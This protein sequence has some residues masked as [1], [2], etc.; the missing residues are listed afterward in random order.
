MKIAI[1]QFPGSNCERESVLAVKRAGMGSFEFLWNMPSENLINCDGYFIVG[2]F[3]YEDRSRAGIIA[4][5]DPVIKVLRQ[6]SEKGKPV[7][8]I[9]NGAQILIETGLVPGFKN[10]N[11][12]MA[13]AANEKKKKGALIGTGFYN[14]WVNIIPSTES[15]KSA[16]TSQLKQNEIM[17]IPVAH[18]EGRFVTSPSIM[19]I[20]KDNHLDTFRYCTT[21]GE[22]NLDFPV[23]PN[24]SI[25]NLAAVSN[26]GGNVMAMMPHPER[27]TSGDPVFS[28][29]REYISKLKK[30]SIPKLDYQDTV[31]IEK[32]NSDENSNELLIELIITDNE[33]VSVE[34]ALRQMDLSVRVKRYTHWEIISNSSYSNSSL[35]KIERSGELFN[36]NKEMV[37]NYKHNSNTLAFLVRD[38]DNASGKRKKDIL[39]HW[40]HAKNI[41]SIESG[42]LWDITVEKGDV[43]SVI[44][45]VLNTHILYNPYS[46]DCLHYEK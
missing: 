4:S 43:V 44:E 20:L 39:K 7:L 18:A 6:E 35:E 24:G 12:G 3:S 32:F 15:D 9:C 26:S 33:A 10:N 29:M 21:K 36:S 37:V 45:E 23:N 13:L 16:F 2:G 22:L 17:R 19:K 8:G 41:K 28:S 46:H 1:I 5:L 42:I 34:N 25:E 11:L 27:S 14:G 38:K 30:I 31:Q 40:F